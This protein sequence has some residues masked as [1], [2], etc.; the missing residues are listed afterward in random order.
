M[1][2]RVVITG[3]GIE[4][5]DLGEVLSLLNATPEMGSQPFTPSAELGKKGLL[6]KD[7]ATLMAMCAASRCLKEGGDFDRSRTG[8]IVACNYGNIDLVCAAVESIQ[9]GRLRELSPLELPNASSNIVA[10]SIAIR[11]KLKSLNIAVCGGANSG[12]QAIALAAQSLRSQ[13]ADSMLV[14]GVEPKSVVRQRLTQ[15][16]ASCSMT[17]VLPTA[18]A[19]NEPTCSLMEGAA[20][21]LLETETAARERG[22]PILAR[23]SRCSLLE[24]SAL[25]ESVRKATLSEQP[26][27]WLT[28]SAA[29]PDVSAAIE[30]CRQSELPHTEAHDLF[31][32]FGE[33]HGLSA[34]LQAVVACRWLQHNRGPVLATSGGRNCRYSSSLIENLDGNM[35]VSNS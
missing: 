13:R 14:V 26:R 1:N 22:S 31:Q 30:S 16:M 5:P 20:A 15:G 10:S 3:I 17:T 4:L 11:F 29:P 12:H 18:E 24:Y 6:G 33:G 21:L 19:D 34:I 9:Q 7:R 23:V 35:H 27:L 8:V 25:C 28:P 2:E 32:H